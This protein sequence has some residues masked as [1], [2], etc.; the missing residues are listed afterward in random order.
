MK[1]AGLTVGGFRSPPSA[2]GANRRLLAGTFGTLR[3]PR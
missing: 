2:R 3:W 1:G